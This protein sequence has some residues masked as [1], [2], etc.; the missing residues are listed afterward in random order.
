MGVIDP[1]TEA[2]N[3]AAAP[4]EGAAPLSKPPEFDLPRVLRR[5]RTGRPVAFPGVFVTATEVEGKPLNMC[6]NRPR[7]AIQMNLSRGQFY[8]AEELAAIAARFP[9]GGVFVDIG[10][11]VGNHSLY[12]ARILEAGRVIPVEPN[13]EV[14]P[15]LLANVATNR[16]QGQF[17]FRGIG[18][19]LSNS[20]GGGFGI[21]RRPRNI[22]GA[23]IIR[24]TGQ[25]RVETGDVLLQGVA[26]SYIKID[27]EGMEMKVLAG[28]A[29]TL[30]QHR[31]GLFVEVDQSNYAAFE[32]WIP[33]AGYRVI[34]KMQRYRANMNYLL[35]AI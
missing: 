11:N 14:L 9:K 22:G 26:P 20:S 12:V 28:L 8:E 27:V 34:D 25:I 23:R 5:L 32:A 29:E 15:V 3:R 21:I 31:P 33:A 19:G 6:W 1:E 2:G 35:E 24:G 4:V 30:R 16:L 10:A 7:D 18:L 13:P 17:D